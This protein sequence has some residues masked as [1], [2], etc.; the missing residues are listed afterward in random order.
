[1]KRVGR[2][3]GYEE[4]TKALFLRIVYASVA[5]AGITL[6]TKI[7]SERKRLAVAP[8]SDRATSIEL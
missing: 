3:F 4:A 2:A 7:S 1:M 8:M 5:Y 6:A